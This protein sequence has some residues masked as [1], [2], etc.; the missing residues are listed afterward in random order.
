MHFNCYF[1]KTLTLDIEGCYIYIMSKLSEQPKRGDPQHCVYDG[2]QCS[3]TVRFC[4]RDTR[5]VN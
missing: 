4:D 2:L 3:V 5:P 1:V